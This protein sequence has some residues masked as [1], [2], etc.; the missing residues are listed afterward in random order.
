MIDD[1]GNDSGYDSDEGVDVK[2]KKSAV[3]TKVANIIETFRKNLI[4]NEGFLMDA[5]ATAARANGGIIDINQSDFSTACK[6]FLTKEKAEKDYGGKNA[7]DVKSL[8]E[9]IKA[10][11]TK[12]EK[13][14]KE[15]IDSEYF[16][17]FKKEMKNYQEEVAGRLSTNEG[18]RKLLNRRFIDQLFID[19]RI[20]DK[21]E[22]GKPTFLHADKGQAFFSRITPYIHDI[23]PELE[24]AMLS[25]LSHQKFPELV[26]LINEETLKFF[27]VGGVEGNWGILDDKKITTENIRQFANSINSILKDMDG[28]AFELEVKQVVQEVVN[29]IKAGNDIP[30]KQK[31]KITKQLF[32][33]LI[34]LDPDDLR[35]NKRDIIPKLAENIE[36]HKTFGSNLFKDWSIS[37]ESLHNVLNH[38]TEKYGKKSEQSVKP[39]SIVLPEEKPNKKIN[40]EISSPIIS[41]A[42]DAIL[43]E[44]NA[45]IKSEQRVEIESKLSEVLSAL[46]PE[47]L[48]KNT[49]ILAKNL[50]DKLVKKGNTSLWNKNFTVDNS[51]LEKIS[52]A[53]K[54]VEEKKSD[55]FVENKIN[56]AIWSH[57]MS[58]SVL[59]AKLSKFL[60]ENKKDGIKE[61]VALK[62]ITTQGLVE[63]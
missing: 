47:Y 58:D 32:Q 8:P 20:M 43:K 50:T 13:M 2:G 3:A 31:E 6:S 28:K 63:L 56:E 14:V 17:D 27:T 24:K 10:I 40:T 4:S 59:E 54:S 12:I 34:K 53:V 52:A 16:A 30:D 7:R 5:F 25:M 46:D 23:P 41:K 15:G 62:K 45:K 61:D 29:K 1:D 11:N 37:T 19:A 55:K 36:K 42:I 9:T 48:K 21:D 39:E 60:D 44:K 51:Q 33:E 57:A 35:R 49:D 38:L 18:I 22:N 26:K